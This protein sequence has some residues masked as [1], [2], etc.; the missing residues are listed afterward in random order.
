MDADDATEPYLVLL[1][2]RAQEG[3]EPSRLKDLWVQALREGVAAAGEALEV[4]SER[5]R[6]VFYGDALRDSLTQEQLED[7]ERVAVRGPTQVA[8]EEMFI[9][10]VLLEAL[11]SV[12]Q[13]SAESEKPTTLTT[14]RR[15]GGRTSLALMR[16]L[17]EYLPGSAG[18]AIAFMAR[19]VHAYLSRPGVRDLIEDGFRRALPD[20]CPAVVVGHSLGS[21]VAYN[22]LR[23]EAFSHPWNIRLFVTLGSP[24]GLRAIRRRLEPLSYPRSVREWLNARDPRDA[25]ALRG[26][27]RFYRPRA[28]AA[29][30]AEIDDIVNT[31]SKHHGVEGYLSDKRIAKR[32]AAALRV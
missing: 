6:F 3:R 21:V 24:L 22:V 15:G 4:K 26:L 5:I 2:G 12:Q 27:E 13:A 23:R 32:I 29:A 25:V 14:H 1:H 28:G 20:S 30:I 10:E 19:D 16:A 31:T 7:V 18:A 9:R 17:D 8:H 11:R